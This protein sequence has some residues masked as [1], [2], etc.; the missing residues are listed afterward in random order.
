MPMRLVDDNDDDDDDDGVDIDDD[1][2]GVDMEDVVV[3][4]V[5]S[6]GA[7]HGTLS[8]GTVVDLDL[9]REEEG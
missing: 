5:F 7:A 2:D 4:R 3:K 8:E 6:T 9:L 1:D